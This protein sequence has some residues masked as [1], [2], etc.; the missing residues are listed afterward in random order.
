MK[1]RKMTNRIA[2]AER[3]GAFVRGASNIQEALTMA[4][5]DGKVKVSESPVSAQVRTMGEFGEKLT[6]LTTGDKF[7]TYRQKLNGELT[8]LGVVGNRYTPIQDVEAFDFL[9]LLIDESGAEIEVVGTIAK[10]KQTVMSIKMPST[11][12]VGGM[13]PIDLG[14][15]AT[16]SHDGSTAF[17]VSISSI[18]LRCT[19]QVAGLVRNAKRKISYKHTLNALG[20]V[21]Q[22]RQTLEMTFAYQDAFEKEVESLIAAKYSTDEFFGLVQQLMPL[23]VPNSSKKQF[24]TVTSA[25]I[26]LMNL[27][28]ADTQA[29][30]FGTKW[31]AYNAV[32]EYADW[33]KPVRG[34][35]DKEIIRA[36]RIL[37][38][39]TE[40]LKEKAL[41]LL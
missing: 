1:G 28:S 21:A 41:A 9:N 16:N 14:L 39:S 15:Y 30:I 5:L 8:P 19:N 17:T 6:T 25:R 38:G 31:A 37:T 26:D 33:V 2:P 20:K 12:L 7:L 40:M 24:E 4:N 29:N 34:G 13:D 35:S 27:W 10:G 18:R 32:A 36:E 11:I 23:D 22:A 3:I